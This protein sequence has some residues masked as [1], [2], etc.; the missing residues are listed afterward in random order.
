VWCGVW[1]ALKA[2][3]L[4]GGFASL[5]RHPHAAHNIYHRKHDENY[6]VLELKDSLRSSRKQKIQAE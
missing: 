5:D 6:V 3:P 2:K 1:V 4:R